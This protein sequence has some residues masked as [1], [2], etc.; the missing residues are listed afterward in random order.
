VC[1]AVS[2]KMCKARMCSAQSADRGDL[3]VVCTRITSSGH[4]SLAFSAPVILKLYS[5]SPCI[6]RRHYTVSWCSENPPV[7]AGLHGLS[8]VLER[9]K[10]NRTRQQEPTPHY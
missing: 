4:R 9:T 10:P 8:D 6:S 1:V 5:A 7:Q 2:T 3:I